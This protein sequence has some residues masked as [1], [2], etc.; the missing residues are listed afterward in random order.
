MGSATDLYMDIEKEVFLM[1]MIS[2]ISDSEEA[3]EEMIS[4]FKDI[5]VDYV[6][7]GSLS[8]FG[9]SGG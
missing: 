1:L 3:I 4:K 5:K 7:G 9:E 2:Y 8:L 6:F